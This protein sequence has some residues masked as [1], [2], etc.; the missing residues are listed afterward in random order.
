MNKKDLIGI[1]G[2]FFFLFLFCGCVT[3]PP[4]MRPQVGEIPLRFRDIPIP[5]DFRFDAKHSYTFEDEVSRIGFL[6]YTTRISPDEIVVFFREEMVKKEWRLV[7]I[8][9]HRGQRILSY[10]KKG[11]SCMITIYPGR[12]ASTVVISVT[13]KPGSRAP[14]RERFQIPFLRRK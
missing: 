1:G 4:I 8:F 14:E 11:E 9:E 12:I 6:R 10:S 5:E 7:N 2:V 13:P 3:I